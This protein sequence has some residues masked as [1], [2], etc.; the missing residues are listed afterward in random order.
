MYQIILFLFILLYVVIFSENSFCLLKTYENA[1][2][3]YNSSQPFYN[4]SQPFYNSSQPFYNS[5]QPFYNNSQ[6]F[7]N[8]SQPFYNNSQPFHNNNILSDSILNTIESQIDSQNVINKK[9]TSKIYNIGDLLNM[10]SYWAGWNRNPHDT[11]DVYNHYKEMCIKFINSILNNYCNL[12]TDETEPI[13]NIGR[14]RDSVDLYIKNNYNYLDNLIKKVQ[15]P[16]TLCVHLRSGD[17][18]IVEDSFINTINTLSNNYNKIIIFAGIHSDTRFNDLESSK[19]NLLTSISKI[20]INKDIEINLEL[21][22]IHLCL[23]RRA[24]NLLIHKGGF[25]ILGSILFSGTNLYATSLLETLNNN[26]LIDSLTT[27]IQVY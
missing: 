14:I 25:S 19:N 21:A 15:D 12:R 17:K 27:K 23:M 24:H 26:E 18:G 13:P 8:N 4:S 1:S 2:N 20:V 11:Q 16:K 3:V 6:P 7:Y 10:P 5:S 22:D 9:N